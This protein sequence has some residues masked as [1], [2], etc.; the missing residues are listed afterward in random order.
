MPS[1]IALLLLKVMLPDEVMI[2]CVVLFFNSMSSIVP[3]PQILTVAVPSM[4]SLEILMLLPVKQ[5]VPLVN[6]LLPDALYTVLVHPVA[7]S[8][9]LPV[10]PNFTALTEIFAF[11]WLLAMANFSITL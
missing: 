1:S 4:V 6:V 8:G 9:P 5:L 7:Q 10:L 2:S 3:V 11:T